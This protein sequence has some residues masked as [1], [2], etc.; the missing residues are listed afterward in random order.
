MRNKSILCKSII[1]GSVMMAFAAAPFSLMAQSASP[2]SSMQQQQ[3]ASTTP[4]TP[5]S[6]ET[7][8]GKVDDTWITTKV[9]SKLAA[10]KGIKASDI[11]VST[12]D[13]VVTLTGTATSTKERTRAEHLAKQVKGVKSVD[14]SG[15]T[16]SAASDSN[17][18]SSTPPTSGG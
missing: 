11:S 13:G 4:S 16:I 1:A 7:V 2:S 3:P 9:K 10:A 17:S 12:T 18:S 8:P 5:S 15:L 6:N 14:G